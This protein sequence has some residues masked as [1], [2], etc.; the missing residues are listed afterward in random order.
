MKPT[1][2]NH[3]FFFPIMIFGLKNLSKPHGNHFSMDCHVFQ[4]GFFRWRI[5]TASRHSVSKKRGFLPVHWRCRKKMGTCLEVIN[6]L[7]NQLTLD[8]PKKKWPKT[9]PISFVPT[10]DLYYSLKK[11]ICLFEQFGYRDDSVD[12]FI[13]LSE[14]PVCEIQDR[15]Q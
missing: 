5:P 1:L 12:V 6:L 3:L 15:Q 9:T 14:A 13:N 7:E 8:S 11:T 2:E 4:S 10:M